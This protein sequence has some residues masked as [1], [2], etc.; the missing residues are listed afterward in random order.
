MALHTGT[1]FNAASYLRKSS[2]GKLPHVLIFFNSLLPLLVCRNFTSVNLVVCLDL[3]FIYLS[4]DSFLFTVAVCE[5]SA[6]Q[7]F[8]NPQGKGLRSETFLLCI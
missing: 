4:Q 3:R 7:N 2:S 5:C 1:I 6:W 8:S